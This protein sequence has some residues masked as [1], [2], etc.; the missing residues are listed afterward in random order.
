MNKNVKMPSV[1]LF[2]VISPQNGKMWHYDVIK[3][4]PG[5]PCSGFRLDGIAGCQEGVLGL[6]KKWVS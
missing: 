3:E 4:A 2:K 5:G 1:L 6:S